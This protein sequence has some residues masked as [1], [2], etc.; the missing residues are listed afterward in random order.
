MGTSLGGSIRDTKSQ[1][2]IAK[3]KHLIRKRDD[4]VLFFCWEVLFTELNATGAHNVKVIF[5]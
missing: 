5:E 2:S 3:V 4:I 1:R